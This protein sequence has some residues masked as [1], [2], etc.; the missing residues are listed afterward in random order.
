MEQSQCERTSRTVNPDRVGDGSNRGSEGPLMDHQDHWTERL[1]ITSI[2]SLGVCVLS[3]EDRID[4]CYD[5]EDVGKNSG[6]GLS[7]V[8]GVLAASVGLVKERL[9]PARGC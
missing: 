6:E 4:H 5:M 2:V 8:D 7:P 1:V 3:N 9:C